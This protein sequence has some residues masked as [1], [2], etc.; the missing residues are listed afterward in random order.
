MTPAAFKAARQRLGLTAAALAR[1]LGVDTRTVQSWEAEMG[2]RRRAPPPTACR[3]MEWMINGYRPPEWPVTCLDK[4]KNQ[5][6]VYLTRE[7]AT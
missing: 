5:G 7:V 6:M 4:R 2:S 1:I 3:V